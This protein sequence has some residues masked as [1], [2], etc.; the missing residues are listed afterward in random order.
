LQRTAVVSSLAAAT[1]CRTGHHDTTCGSCGQRA[2][3]TQAPRNLI[4][5]F[6]L[7]LAA[8]GI[9]KEDELARTVDL[10]ALR[11]T[12]GTHL[13]KNGVAPRTAQAAMR[14]SSPNL[15]MNAYTDPSLLDVAGALEALPELSLQDVAQADGGPAQRCKR[16]REDE[17]SDQ[18]TARREAYRGRA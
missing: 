9:D 12:F 13:S 16:A 4:K 17:P 10:H 15:T 8:A 18:R 5:S 11:H 2:E 6:N 3:Q 1:F 14:H 7:D